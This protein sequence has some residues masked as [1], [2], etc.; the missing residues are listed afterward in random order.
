MNVRLLRLGMGL[1]AP[2][3]ALVISFGIISLI[4]IAAGDPVGSVWDQILQWP[5]RRNLS[6]I[7]DKSTIFYLSGIAVAIG[8]RM[9]L[10]NIGVEGQ[11]LVAALVAGVIGGEAWV[12]GYLNTGLA[13]L[14]GMVAGALYAGIAGFLRAYRGVSEV[15]STIMLNS[16]AVGLTAFLLREFKGPQPEGSFIVTT[17]TLPESSWIP[18]IS[19]GEGAAT[20][21]YGFIY[22]AAFVGL[23]YWFLINKTRFGFD[24]RATG[25]SMTA[26][27][28]SGINTKRMIVT[29]ML[30]SG[31]FAGLVGLPYI[32][33]E[34]HSYGSTFPAGLGFTG[35]AV[36]LIGR[37][38]PVGVALGAFLFAFLDEQTNALQI[39]AGVSP[40][41]VKIMQGVILLT[42]VIAYEVVRRFGVRIE[43]QMVSR[44]LERARAAEATPP[45][46]DEKEAAR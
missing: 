1:V 7:I 29:A 31:A 19:I 21:I 6:N 43:Q 13:I 33:G 14:A 8:F 39:V 26:A 25:W 37:N 35:I 22:I 40:E 34:Y 41:I 5:E 16:V 27:V 4:L 9:N 32:F 28:A 44:E 2:V 15:I 23:A 3:L 20:E 38:H 10:F 24:L 11:F 12:S 36:A 17:K 42:V 18:N 45:P 30:L 46:A